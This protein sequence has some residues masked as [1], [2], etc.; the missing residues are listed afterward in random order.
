MPPTHGKIIISGWGL[1]SPLGHGAWPTFRALLAGGTIADR[2]ADLLPDTDPVTLVRSV[3]RVSVT[4]HSAADPAIDLAE[5]AAREAALM[6]AAAPDQLHC[7]LGSSKGAVHTL[8]TAADQ[9]NARLATA[10]R[11]APSNGN[12]Q[13]TPPQPASPT[14]ADAHTALALGPHGYLNNHL[15]RRLALTT[16]DDPLPPIVHHTV[17]ACA[18]GLAALNHAKQFI[19]A[20]RCQSTRDRALVVTS[21][22]ALLPMFI[23]SYQRLGVLAPLEPSRY[24]ARPLDRRRAGFILAEV[25]AAVILEACDDPPPNAIELL[26]TAVASEAHDMVRPNPTMAALNHVAEHLLRDHPVDVIHPHAPGTVEHDQTELLTYEK[27]WRDHHTDSPFP[28]LYASKGALGHT[29]GASGLVSL[30]I[31]AISAR[32]GRLP[33]MP[34][35]TQPIDTPFAITPTSFDRPS[36]HAVFAAGFAGH[37]A[38][39]LIRRHDP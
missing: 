10:K 15:T 38:A 25:G 12:G 14:T 8:T 4:P 3:G 9:T 6:A 21:E 37:V 26:D 22:S 19:D 18:S 28:H 39:A 35:L 29:L 34:W 23:H 13:T 32:T 16:A 11:D 31:A 27:L 30:V 7:F 33:P 36:T 24:S 5:R 2:A 17:A 1:F 20:G